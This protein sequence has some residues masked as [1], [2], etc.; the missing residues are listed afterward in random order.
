[1]N[2]DRFLKILCLLL[3]VTQT[4]AMLILVWFAASKQSISFPLLHK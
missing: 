2:P 3:I 4:T 1:M